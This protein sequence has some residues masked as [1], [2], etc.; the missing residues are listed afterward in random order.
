MGLSPTSDTAIQRP[1]L[2]QAVTEG[3]VLRS[4]F[5]ALAVMP[6]LWVPVDAANYTVLPKEYLFGVPDDARDENG[7]YNRDT[8]QFE[9]GFY[10]TQD[11]GLET[12]LDDRRAAR[13]R[14]LFDYELAES[15]RKMMEILRAHEVRVA[16]KIFNATNFTAHAVS[17][18]WDDAANATPKADVVAGKKTLAAGGIE[19]NA[20]V[21]TQSTMFDLQKSADVKSH[22]YQLFPDAAK[23]GTIT[24]DHLRSYFEVEQIL[25]ANA[26][27]NTAKK[28]QAASLSQVWSNEY[29]MLCRVSTSP[30][31]LDPCLGRTFVWNEGA[32]P[33]EEAI[34]VEEYREEGVRGNVLRVRWDADPALMQSFD[35]DGAAKS[36][37]FQAC[38]YLLSNITT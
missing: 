6:I 10:R 19:A 15:N 36:K 2:G 30:D 37:I 23:T 21:I 12:V 7:N 17:N 8:G 4:D 5:I 14:R 13:Y 27:K 31:T 1:D 22:V 9:S 28:G 33:S 18:E 26:K 24:L 29:A 20:L 35:E 16:A 34:I 38:G 3:M 11:R 25:V 32:A